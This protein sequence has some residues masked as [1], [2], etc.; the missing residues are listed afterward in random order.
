MPKVN[1]KTPS[2]ISWKETGDISIKLLESSDGD[3][4][5]IE[6][7]AATFGGSPDRYGDII[8]KEAFKK[9]LKNIANNA[10]KIPMLLGHSR[11]DVLGSWYEFKEDKHGLL[12]RGQINTETSIGKDTYS[13]IKNGHIRQLS[14]GYV[15]RDYEKIENDWILKEI[16]LLEV[17]IVSIPAN[18]LAVLTDI[19]EQTTNNTNSHQKD[20]KKMPAENPS[21]SQEQN[22]TN[23]DILQKAIDKLSEKAD[24]N[25]A[26]ITKSLENAQ[27]SIGKLKT[28][29]EAGAKEFSEVKQ[30]VLDLAQQVQKPEVDF[31]E[32]SKSIETQIKDS[33]SYKR[34]M[35]GGSASARILVKAV[36]VVNMATTGDGAVGTSLPTAYRADGILPLQRPQHRMRSLIPS[37]TVANQDF[38]IVREV[39]GT[40]GAGVFADGAATGQS[41]VKTELYKVSAIRIGHHMFVTE[42]TLRYTDLISALITTNLVFGIEAIEDAQILKGSGS[43]GNMKGLVAEATAYAKPS[44]FEADATYLDRIRAMIAQLEIAHYSPT[45]ILMHPIDWANIETQK[46]GDSKYLVGNPLGR[47]GMTLWGY[48]VVTSHAIQQGKCLVGMFSGAQLYDTADFGIEMGHI[49]SQFIENTVT[50]KISRDVA[51]AVSQPRAF[52]YGDIKQS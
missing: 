7:Y 33:D 25:N 12:V 10:G 48:P 24:K 45:G 15:L 28:D 30:A 16:E 29:S 32:E 13:N 47:M 46:D 36:S 23:V 27:E 18:E 22:T 20:K 2:P 8:D 51:L 26:E 41:D 11:N 19:K 42:R 34:Y 14:I 40:D 37:A 1:V 6:G 35:D 49:G 52:V 17:S 3:V 4:G 31:G 5:T 44:G 38:E 21:P 9:T 39:A 50:L 43:G